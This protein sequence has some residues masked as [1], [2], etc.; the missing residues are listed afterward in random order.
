MSSE[1]TRFSFRQECEVSMWLLA[2]GPVSLSDG[3]K[4]A[5]ERE[6]FEL[7]SGNFSRYTTNQIFRRILQPEILLHP[8]CKTHRR[9]NE[10]SR[11]FPEFVNSVKKGL[12]GEGTSQTRR[13]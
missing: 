2:D 9:M 4:L 7:H 13:K 5:S 11:K 3:V 12:G 8:T 6:S 1:S 10:I